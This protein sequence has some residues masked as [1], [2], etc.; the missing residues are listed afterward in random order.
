MHVLMCVSTYI[1]DTVG[2]CFYREGHK[3]YFY[4]LDHQVQ[5]IPCCIAMLNLLKVFTVNFMKYF[6][7]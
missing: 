7:Q 2:L 6:V 1:F 3:K 4:V 5:Q